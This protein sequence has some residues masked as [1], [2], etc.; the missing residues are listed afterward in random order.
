MGLAH[1][2]T[3]SMIVTPNRPIQSNQNQNADKEHNPLQHMCW[4]GKTCFHSPPVGQGKQ[5]TSKSSTYNLPSPLL[6]QI[7]KSNVKWHH[8]CS[9]F[10][11]HVFSLATDLENSIVPSCDS[12]LQE[13]KSKTTALLGS[14]AKQVE[15]N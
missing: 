15:A 11:E 3:A 13:K 7:Y 8:L 6:F 14:I 12:C 2:L 10:Y 4:G 1:N 5:P 9:L